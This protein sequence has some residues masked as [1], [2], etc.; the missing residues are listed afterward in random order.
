MHRWTAF[1]VLGLFGSSIAHAIQPVQPVPPAGYDDPG[2]RPADVL[3]QIIKRLRTTLRD[4]YSI[5]DLTVCELET[6]HAFNT[7]LGWRP[8]RWMTKITLNS[9]NAYGGYSGSTMYTVT[10]EGGEVEEIT[11]FRGI[12]LL[13]P[14]VNARLLAAAQACPRTPDTEIQR[15]I[16]DNGS[17]TPTP[18]RG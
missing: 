5:R 7:P 10:F 15:L 8:A 1:V 18:E 11:Q 12:D 16:Q 4:P 17:P 3:P 13:S 6:R 9:R 2:P 14:Q